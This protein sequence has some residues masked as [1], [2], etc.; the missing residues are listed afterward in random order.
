[1]LGINFDKYER[2]FFWTKSNP[3][4]ISAKRIDDTFEAQ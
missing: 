3:L 1:M 4:K 2:G